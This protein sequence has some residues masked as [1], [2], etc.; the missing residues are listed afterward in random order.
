MIRDFRK[1][2]LDKVMELWLETNISA[3]S[4]IENEYWTKNFDAVK[5]MMPNAI[6]YIFEETDSIQGFIGL[7]DD[8]IAGI[9]V[10]VKLQSKGIGKKLL[11]YVK[12]KHTHLFLNAYKNNERAVKFYLR[13]GFLVSKEQIDKN[14]GEVEL[15]MNWVK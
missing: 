2:D 11:D 4:F 15:S 10:S 9:F 6:L 5:G 12:S 8:Y 3:H 1:Q 13:E 7:M 14:T